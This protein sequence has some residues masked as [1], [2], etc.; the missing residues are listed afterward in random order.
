MARQPR[1]LTPL[2]PASLR[3]LA[4]TYAARYAT[5]RGKLVQ[6]LHRKLRER[7]WSGEQAPDPA[8][9]AEHFADLGYIDDEAFARMK[10]GALRRRGLG[11]MRVGIALKTAGIE[12]DLAARESTVEPEAAFHIALHFARRKRIGPFAMTAPDDRTRHRWMG[13]LLRAGHR[14][15]DCRKILALSAEDATLLLQEDKA[16]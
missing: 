12:N 6:Y 15:E 2:D 16:L 14:S 11:A 4:L 10:A 5:T 8:G 7:G 13:S 9:L 1:T 3:G